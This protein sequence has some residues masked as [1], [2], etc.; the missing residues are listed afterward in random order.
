M[1]GNCA[2]LPRAACMQLMG[3]RVG[4]KDL[5]LQILGICAVI[6]DCCCLTQ[7]FE[8]KEVGSVLLHLLP[9]L[10]APSPPAEVTSKGFKCTALFRPSFFSFPPFR[11]QILT[12]Y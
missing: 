5:V 9:F 2:H 10:Q 11:S 7:S 8:D 12:T 3:A 6:I 1:A 4:K